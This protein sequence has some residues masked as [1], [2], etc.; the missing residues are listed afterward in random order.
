MR[1]VTMMAAAAIV[2]LAACGGGAPKQETASPEKTQTVEPTPVFHDDFEEGD[3]T[4]WAEGEKAPEGEAETP[5]P[6]T[7]PDAGTQ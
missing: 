5:A 2:A 4:E 3:V 7:A 1:L 6:E